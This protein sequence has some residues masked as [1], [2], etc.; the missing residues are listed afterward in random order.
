[1]I[2]QVNANI[3][4]NEQAEKKKMSKS[5][6]VGI[7]TG[8]MILT[9]GAGIT[10]HLI[11]R[12]A[13]YL[14]TDNA[15]VTTNLIAISSN[16]PGTLERFTVYE[17]RY[18]Y[19]NEVLG[20]VQNG[21]AMRS[22]VDGL[23]IHSTAVQDQMVSPMEAVAVIADLNRIHIQAN[24]REYDITRVQLGQLVTVTIDGFGNRQFSG[25]VA[26]I[27]RITNAELTGTAMFFNTGGTFTRV[28]HLIPIEINITDDIALENL[29]G[30]NANVRIS[31]RERE[32]IQPVQIPAA[33][34]IRVNGVVESTESRN[35]YSTLGFMIDRVYAEVG[36]FVREGQRLAVLD[37]ADLE[38]AIVQQKA[39]I[40][41]ARQSS[42]V[43]I[44]DTQRMQ[45]EAQANL[46][47]NTN[48]HIVNAE[49][50]LSA[51][52]SG[53]EMAQ[54]NYNDARRDYNEGTN[55][56]ILTAESLL[57][58]ARLEFDRLQVS[59]TNLAALYAGG[60]V[61]S[62]ELRQSEI[63]LNHARNQYNDAQVI[64]NNARENQTRTLN[65]LRLAQQSAVTAR[66]SAQEMVNAS[67]VAAMQDIERLRTSVVSAEISG[68]LEYM[69]TALE[70]L[71]RHL[72]DAIITSPIT[73]TVTAVIARE[74]AVG[75]GLMF[76][77]ED[78]ES[79]RIITSFREYD[80]ANIAPGMEVSISSDGTGDAVYT[81]RIS[82]IN[83]AAIPH[84]PVVQFEAEVDVLSENTDLRIGMN[85][86]I[87]VKLQ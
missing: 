38:L 40:E 19:E 45:N 65:Q 61:S 62:E 50:A 52:Q 57:R 68:N 54:R 80:L 53:L 36:D 56:Q 77:V 24:I 79:L 75:A 23:V 51:A 9:V 69:E 55:P 20:W 85:A 34:T 86:R 37:T 81:G 25:Y 10:F 11:Q 27:G 48:I 70:Q 7:L 35:V 72:N 58:T 82:R 83:P 44:S 60:V 43:I 15:R 1:M 18:V 16:V 76:V 13:N 2:E 63:V 3:Q 17:G 8:V 31:V 4:T 59:H 12:S 14:T 73:G 49:A 5:L 6:I 33:K 64:Y 26:N 84:S 30:V 78:M 28:T 46:A 67:R 71:K 41:V 87:M 32:I 42:E 29:I 74:G 22:P 66:N 21:E 47:N 39:A